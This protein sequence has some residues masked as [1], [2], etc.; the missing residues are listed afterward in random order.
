MRPSEYGRSGGRADQLSGPG[1]GL[2]PLLE[3]RRAR[4]DRHVVAVDMLHQAPS[5]GRQVEDHLGGMQAQPVEVDDVHVRLHAR[6]QATA[7]A[8]AEEIRRLAGL[9][10]HH[11]LERQARPARAVAHPVGQ[12]RGVERGIADHPAMRA[13][14]RQA[15]QGVRILDQLAHDLEIAMH[16]VGD[17]EINHPPAIA[18]DQIVV[19]ELGR[20]HA[21][22]LRHRGDAALRRRL[23]VRRIAQQVHAVPARRD[24]ARQRRQHLEQPRRGLLRQDR[25]A[26]FGIAQLGQHL[27]RRQLGERRQ[28]PRA[29]RRD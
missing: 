22:A 23:V 8:E 21:G 11:I 19:A 20:A 17:G 28:R 29:A 15:E 25:A 27:G 26:H 16:V 3:D 12:H 9:R 14:V 24:L 5:A 10:L 2:L 18:A 6:L 13:A 1:P 4:A 7:I